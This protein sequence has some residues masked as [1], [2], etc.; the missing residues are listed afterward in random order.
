[1]TLAEANNEATYRSTRNPVYS[2]CH[3]GI[4]PIA[5]RPNA[6]PGYLPKL[7]TRRVN[8]GCAAAN[9]GLL[10]VRTQCVDQS[11]QANAITDS[12]PR[13][14]GSGAGGIG[15]VPGNGCRI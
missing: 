1:V 14:A 13:R 3:P 11:G 12:D 2:S 7:H 15:A 6:H 5:K 4:V 10:A 8:C 9:L